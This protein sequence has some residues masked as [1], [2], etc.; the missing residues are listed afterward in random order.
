[1]I[2]NLRKIVNLLSV[3]AVGGFLLY[4]CEPEADKLGEQFFIDGE[5]EANMKSYDLIAY[6]ITNNDT[7]RS[8]AA[9]LD[10]AT[11][12]VFNDPI[13]GKQN[14][15]YAT[16]VRLSTYDPDFGTNPIV[17]SVVMVVKPYYNANNV[18]TT[19]NDS[20]VY[21]DGNVD[22]KVEIKKYPVK[23]FGNSTTT[24]MNVKVEEVT[25][26]LDG[27]SDKQYSNKTLTLGSVLGQTTFDGNVKS[28]SITKDSDASSLYSSDAGIR[29]LL[30]KNFFQSKIV[31][32]QD[33]PELQNTA[34]FIRYIKGLK[35]SMTDN[36]GY[37]MTF[38]PNSVDLKM[39]YKYDKTDNGVTTT[40]HTV[41]P[42]ALG[43]GNTHIGLGQFDRS[44]LP[45]NGYNDHVMSIPNTTSG[46]S[47]IFLQAM[48]GPSMGV[49]IPQ[50]T[51]DQLKQVYQNDKAAIISA[52]IRVY[53]DDSSGMTSNLPKPD[54]F[55]IITRTATLEPTKPYTY[56][57]TNDLLIY[58]SLATFQ[59]YKAHNLD[60]NPAYYDFSF[61]KSLKDIVEG[62]GTID[63]SKQ[64]FIISIGNF[65]STT[66]S[67]GGVVLQG[68][69]VT[70]RARNYKRVVLVGSD[71]SNPN[72]IQLKVT[73]G[74]K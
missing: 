40:V 1:M 44:G 23:K 65:L 20:Y 6:N 71:L 8:D 64:D 60:Q 10:S 59:L 5:A 22:A 72:R 45:A 49:K 38:F 55:N 67:S 43:A 68:N 50:S 37:L 26:F 3:A 48:G 66:A 52:K 57:F 2:N 12:G 62:D 24:S 14:A 25:T 16:Q 61:T 56:S 39:Y 69:N 11:I 42:F 27:P 35:I 53:T 54:A 13:F 21:P 31:A 74:T 33:K 63:Y 18:T 29:I 4:S 46:N 36:D 17:D 32:M 51:V 41:Y 28:V 58:G 15:S 30:D 47:K 34:N 19:T 73:Y 7:V 9:R 70:T